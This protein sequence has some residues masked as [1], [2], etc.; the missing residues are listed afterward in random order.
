MVSMVMAMRSFQQTYS[1]TLC[2]MES[3]RVQAMQD[4]QENV[5]MQPNFGGNECL[6]PMIPTFALSY[7]SDAT[8]AAP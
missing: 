3:V 4:I 7:D 1:E 5:T 2:R 8:P 6:T